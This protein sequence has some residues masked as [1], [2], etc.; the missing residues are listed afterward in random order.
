M[1]HTHGLRV[2]MAHV[3]PQPETYRLSLKTPRAHPSV[4]VRVGK[5]KR[6]ERRKTEERREKGETDELGV[7]RGKKGKSY[8]LAGY[9]VR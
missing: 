3:S 9:S 7:N 6:D 8:N 1:I 5:R 2:V 4:P